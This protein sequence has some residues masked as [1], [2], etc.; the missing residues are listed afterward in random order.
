MRILIT[1]ARGYLG[2]Y[3]VKMLS[4]KHQVIALYRDGIANN[5]LDSHNVTWI[6]HQLDEVWDFEC[7]ADIILH[8]A[9]QHYL[10]RRSANPREFINSNLLGLLN[11]AEFA[12]NNNV[13]RFLYFSTVTVHGSIGSGVVDERTPLNMPDLYGITKY[14]GEVILQEYS[15]NFASTVVR[16]PGIVG[17]GL[18][19]GRPWLVGVLQRALKGE[20]IAY[21]NPEALFNNVIDLAEIGR[22]V[23]HL[24][25]FEPPQSF[26]VVYLSASDPIPVQKVIDTLVIESKSKSEVDSGAPARSSFTIDVSHLVDT[27]GFNPCQTIDIIR[28]FVR[29]N[30][31]RWL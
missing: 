30:L 26:D 5:R 27:Y 18:D 21:A 20:V 12:K 15:R 2:S 17:P 28:R 11:A 19:L 10:S 29:S 3:L 7:R 4:A 13:P 9:T 14:A 25:T 23:Q 1:G 16:L 22:F 6:E 24:L 8:T 31:P